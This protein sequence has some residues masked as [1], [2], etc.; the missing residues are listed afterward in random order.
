MH[1]ADVDYYKVLGVS[2]NA[3]ASEIKQKYRELSKKYHPDTMGGDTKRMSQIN[4]A[5]ATLSDPSKRR[6]YYPPSAHKTYTEPSYTKTAKQPQRSPVKKRTVFEPEEEPENQWFVFLSY[7]LAIPIAILVI[8]VG[9][10]AFKQILPKGKTVIVEQPPKT[11]IQTTQTVPATNTPP[12]FTP[13][14]N[15]ENEVKRSNLFYSPV[16]QE[17]AE[18]IDQ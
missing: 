18:T 13:P 6:E 9:L 4:E 14:N 10:P 2:A 15:Q 3:T 7:V 16:S 12:N 5:Y 11:P 1:I 8:N 17:R